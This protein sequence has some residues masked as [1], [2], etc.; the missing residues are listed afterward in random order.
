MHIEGTSRAL[1]ATSLAILINSSFIL[2][3]KW[4]K[5]LNNITTKFLLKSC[6]LKKYFMHK[7]V[8]RIRLL[9]VILWLLLIIIMYLMKHK[10][11][12]TLTVWIKNTGIIF[13][14]YIY[15]VKNKFKYFNTS[16]FWITQ[17]KMCDIL[18]L[19]QGSFKIYGL[20]HNILKLI[21]FVKK[22]TTCYI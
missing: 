1:P 4:T 12:V 13:L 9:S 2:K 17:S 16:D 15:L 10:I 18:L 19:N 6:Q 8:N 14:H 11:D 21:M 3:N 5:K 20:Y 22:S 7:A